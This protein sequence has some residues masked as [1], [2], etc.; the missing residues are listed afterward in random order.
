MPFDFGTAVAGIS[1]RMFGHSRPS[2]KADWT[3]KNTRLF[4][5]EIER[6]FRERTPPKRIDWYRRM[7]RKG[8]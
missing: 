8:N 1:D 5:E 3:D 7:A 2:N 6:R 4:Q